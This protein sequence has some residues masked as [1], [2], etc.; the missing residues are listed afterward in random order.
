V[1]MLL[2]E[3]FAPAGLGALGE[4]GDAAAGYEI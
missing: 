4:N 1:E 3:L 2:I